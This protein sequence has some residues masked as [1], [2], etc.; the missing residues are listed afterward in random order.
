MLSDPFSKLFPDCGTLDDNY[1]LVIEAQD[2]PKEYLTKIYE[3]VGLTRADFF[4]DYQFDNVCTYLVNTQSTEKYILKRK[5]ISYLITK[6]IEG[7]HI[8]RGTF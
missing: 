4:F 6:L 3:R 8:L 1:K 2:N 7:G 5:R